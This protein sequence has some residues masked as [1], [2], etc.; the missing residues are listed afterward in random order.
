V[1]GVL[2]RVADYG[3]EVLTDSNIGAG[4]FVKDPDGQLVELLPMAYR[5]RLDSR[6]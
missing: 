1:D 5:R 3:G 4:V 2:A 6:S